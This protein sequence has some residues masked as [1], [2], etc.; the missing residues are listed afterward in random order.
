MQLFPKVARAIG[1]LST[2]SIGLGA[3]ELVSLQAAAHQVLQH[4]HLDLPLSH[5]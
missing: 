3:C 2:S 5:A 4:L 1:V